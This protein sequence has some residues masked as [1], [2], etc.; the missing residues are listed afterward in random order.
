MLLFFVLCNQEIQNGLWLPFKYFHNKRQMNVR[1]KTFWIHFFY[2]SLS[3]QFWSVFKGSIVDT[4]TIVIFFSLQI[5]STSILTFQLTFNCIWIHPKTIFYFCFLLKTINSYSMLYIFIVN[6]DFTI[7]VNR[8]KSTM[9]FIYVLSLTNLHG[10]DSHLDS[11][12]MEITLTHSKIILS[13]SPTI[14]IK[15]S[16]S[17]IWNP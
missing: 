13:A 11:F 12:Q 17:L 2:L 4:K 7:K 14:S 10:N 9:Q 5:A 6:Y 16:F 8:S 3:W 1:K 15:T